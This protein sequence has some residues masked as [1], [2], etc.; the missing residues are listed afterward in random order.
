M[1]TRTSTNSLLN[2]VIYKGII[3]VPS[4][5]PETLR[6]QTGW[7]Y[8]VLT[9]VTDNDPTKTNTGQSFLLGDEIIWN[10]LSWT[11][12]GSVDIWIE[13]INDVYTVNTKSVNLRSK[14]LLNVRTEKFDIHQANPLHEEGN[15]FYDYT[16]HALSY[17][18]ESS[19]VTVNLGQ[20][21]IIRVRNESGSDILNGKVVYPSGVLNNE[22]LVGLANAHDKE[23]CRLIGVATQDILNGSTGYVTKFGE[24][25]GLDTSSFTGGILYLSDTPGDLTQI[26]PTGGSYITQI[27]A[28]KTI[29][30]VNGSIVVDINTT[31]LTVEAAQ[32][33][34]FSP[35]TT[36]LLT[37]TNTSPDRT[38]TLSPAVDGEFDFYQYGDKYTK[39]IDSIQL[40]DEE[41]L[42]IIYYN[43]GI[44]AYLKN[45]TEVQIATLMLN[46]PTIAYVYW[47]AVD[48]K[49]E[50]LGNE[51]HKLGMN[52]NTHNYLH[53]VLKFRYVSGLAPNN[54]VS[55]A[56]GNLITS[57]Q[58]GLDSG[59]IADEDLF[60][61]TNP[62]AS[63]TGLPIYY[64]SGTY[65]NTL[66]R[67][68]SNPGFS[69]IT[70]GTGRLAY[71]RLN[72]G[73]YSL[74]EVSNGDFVCCHVIS[75]NHNEIGKRVVA[76]VGQTIYTTLASAKNGAQTE[77]S[78]LKIINILPQEVKAIA[79]FIFQ[80]SDSYSNAVKAR[81]RSVA[82]GVDYV[83]FRNIQI[84]GFSGG[85]TSISS[86]NDTLFQLYDNLNS[87]KILQFNASSITAGT[88]KTITAADRNLDLANPVFDTATIPTI[89]GITNFTSIP[90]SS[91]VPVN[92]ND[93]PN[94]KYVHDTFEPVFSKNT[95]FNKNYETSASNIKMDG[96][97][98]VGTLDI[99]AHSDH[100]HPSDT[101]KVNNTGD[102]VIA[103]IKTFSS[104]PISSGVPLTNFQITN[105]KYVDDENLKDVHLIG[106][107]TIDGIKTFNNFPLT[108]SGFPIN[109]YEVTNKK[110]II[111]TYQTKLVNSAGLASALND[112]TGTG[113]AVFNNSPTLITPVANYLT[114]TNTPL[115]DTDASTKKYVDDKFP[116]QEG[117]LFLNDVT[118]CNA[119]SSKHGF[120]PRLSDVSTQFLNGQ[121]NFT[122]PTASS[123]NDYSLTTFTGQTSITVTH[124]FNTYPIVQVIS[125]IGEV[126]I[127]YTI[128]HNSVNQFT[129]TFISSSSG[130]IIASIGSPQPQAITTVSNNYS[131]LNTDRIISVI[132]SGVTIILPTLSGIIG[133]EY[134]IDN[135]STGDIY[136][137][138]IVGTIEGEIVQTIPSDCAMNIFA[139]SNTKWRIY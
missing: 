110:Y 94:R 135:S 91:G 79:T 78:M 137:S 82:T 77:I 18:N 118:T 108:P 10:G 89:N 3:N 130:S 69:V 90:T 119:T 56:S 41:G 92:N 7:I 57:A 131:A 24:V 8:V 62:I 134:I 65:T 99:L 115:N 132:A 98:N 53:R 86:F 22:V 100:I 1:S 67:S 125:A 112:E 29:D 46:N 37:F 38:L 40:P 81:I 51:L 39:T 28:V 48:K 2:R 88:T 129:V 107:Q 84:A 23:K 14:D 45:T 133:H 127:P 85:S 138:G 101:T 60:F 17:Y 124:N 20:E 93:I 109:D 63:I 26:K 21:S 103:G 34:G 32:G 66:L 5:F 72:A 64:L 139:L 35:T 113:V 75:V 30:A 121:G 59:V 58:F 104:I 136:A 11:E 61:D 50:Y 54:I 106:N 43:L 76:F 44:I 83:D 95:A 55:D 52:A 47:N 16:K 71:N 15:I 120:L 74:A 27:A 122:T 36:A 114:L 42:Y 4:D 25:G 33:L 96:I 80:T 117:S 31:E 97:A 70:T 49:C 87:T 13:D 128:K 6:V 12:L 73:T 9:A 19:G 102:E 111:D 126:E 105:K 123:T 116:I 68:T